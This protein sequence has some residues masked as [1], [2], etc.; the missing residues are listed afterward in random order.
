[1][2]KLFILILFIITSSFNLA[3]ASDYNWPNLKAFEYPTSSEVIMI[4]NIVKNIRTEKFSHYD[5]IDLIVNFITNLNYD[6]TKYKDKGFSVFVINSLLN[7]FIDELPGVSNNSKA[8]TFIEIHEL[9][10]DYTDKEVW[11][12]IVV[13]ILIRKE[14]DSIIEIKNLASEFENCSQR[15]ISLLNNIIKNNKN[16][17][18]LCSYLLHILENKAILL[19]TSS[20]DE[21]LKRAK[22]FDKLIN[23]YP[24][25]EFAAIACGV[26]ASFLLSYIDKYPE[27]GDEI[28]NIIQNA[29]N[30]YPNFYDGISNYYNMLYK[31]L[32]QLYMSKNNKNEA[33]KIFD[34]LNGNDED[35]MYLKKELED[36]K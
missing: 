11:N 23:E 13:W 7:N 15:R 34:K 22:N 17:A 16:Y 2:K 18:P 21:V 32:I 36:M 25:T 27:F 12:K 35:Y 1:M 31:T 26:K 20:K 29:I 5:K 33:Q 28:F 24:N 4:K 8:L 3:Y 14:A 30:K 6:I 9:S 10:D 19:P